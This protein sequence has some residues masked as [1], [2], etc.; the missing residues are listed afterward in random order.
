MSK[1]RDNI[2]CLWRFLLGSLNRYLRFFVVALPCR[3]HRFGESLPG[4]TSG[5]GFLLLN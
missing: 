3:W 2:C 5:E 1:F 4:L